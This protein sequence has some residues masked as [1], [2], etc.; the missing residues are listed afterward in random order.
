MKKLIVFLFI[1]SIAINTLFALDKN[2]DIFINGAIEKADYTFYLIYNNEEIADKSVIDE[3]FDISKISKTKPFFVKRTAGNLNK[4][5]GVTIS[6]SASSFV[7][8]FD[9]DEKYDTKVTPKVTIDETNYTYTKVEYSNEDIE[10]N[11]SLLIKAGKNKT[12]ENIASFFFTINGNETI[13]AGD[14]ESTIMINYTY[15]Q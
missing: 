12:S 9:N 3:T 10:G 6:I 2:R 7:G 13:P 1:A 8:N 5:L 15:I 4:D 11:I 14:Y